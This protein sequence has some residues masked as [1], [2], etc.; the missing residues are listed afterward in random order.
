MINISV[1]V[2]T[3]GDYYRGLG[4]GAATSGNAATKGGAASMYTGAG[5]VTSG[6]VTGGADT[7]GAG[8]T[9][10][11]VDDAEMQRALLSPSA[12]EAALV[13]FCRLA[14]WQTN[15]QT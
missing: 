7:T 14:S 2:T 12:P 9:R 15:E 10:G 4:R 5:A 6:E 3:E 13:R 8:T 11:V 1:M